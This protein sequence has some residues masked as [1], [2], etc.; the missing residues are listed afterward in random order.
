MT[1]MPTANDPL[2]PWEMLDE[3]I[4]FETPWFKIHKKHMRT[5]GGAEL[6]YYIHDAPDS[7]IC[8]CV[9][10]DNKI[11]IERQYRPAVDKVSI[12]YPA[13]GIEGE[14][15]SQEHAMLRELKEETGFVATSITKIAVL[16][17]EPAFSGARMHVFVA[18]G[19][20]RTASLQE[21]TESIVAAFVTPAEILQL[22]ADSAMNCT[23]CV[24]A[25]FLAFKE[26][27]WLTP[28]LP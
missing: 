28:A 7:V 12:D 20:V 18:R 10:D 1:N 3:N 2:Q 8:V 27:G 15:I 26:F 6:D 22:I 5:A 21:E 25:T 24:S 4:A 17:K 14:D 11:L 19:S 16:D 9:N 13:G 23:F